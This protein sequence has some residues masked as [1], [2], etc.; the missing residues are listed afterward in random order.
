[1]LDAFES[2]QLPDSSDSSPAEQGPAAGRPPVAVKSGI[3]SCSNCLA[4][5]PIVH[6]VPIMLDYE[7]SLHREFASQNATR[8]AA[9]SGF[10]P[11]RGTPRPGELLTQR[12]FTTEWSGL[13]N[14]ELTFT[15]THQDREDFLRIE[16]DWPD[17]P[18]N[19]K[20]YRLLNVGCG[21]G[22]E[23]I[24]LQRV[25]E[26]EVFGTDLNL[27]L[28]ESGHRI[29]EM[30]KV[31]TVVASLYAL[32]YRPGAFDL[33]YSHG[34]LHHTHSTREGFEKI[35]S[36]VNER[37]MIYIWVYAL[38]DF[39]RN[40]RKRISYSMEMIFRPLLA[41][42]PGWLQAPWIH[43]LAA[44]HFLEYR[45]AGFNRRKWRFKNSL[46]SV[47][48]RWTCRYAH[49]HSFHD[50]MCWFQEQGLEI[51]LVDSLAYLKRF[52]FPLIGIGI[53]GVKKSSAEQDAAVAME[54]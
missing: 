1:M 42:L 35:C 29:A 9:H 6:F 3:L 19:R 34:V 45:L 44:W 18:L 47:R 4:W 22:L 8:M 51:K 30:P 36:Y 7:L 48:D 39:G 40:L 20:D 33:V 46:H 27:S 2:Q 5:Y 25:T 10:T 50:V 54:L 31:H 43:A 24:L 17:W 49:R 52:G 37:G 41:R 32:P 15:Y 26:A 28:L 53:R 12:S 21:Y 13:G 38:E 14:D 11:P 16:L 23:A